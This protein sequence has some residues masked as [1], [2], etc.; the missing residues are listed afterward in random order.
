MLSA[1]LPE[2][3]LR[4]VATGRRRANTGSGADVDVKEED[5]RR[6]LPATKADLLPMR[7]L[8]DADG[9]ADGA[10]AGDND[11]SLGA[12]TA[13]ASDGGSG[14]AW[15]RRAMQREQERGKKSKECERVV[16]SSSLSFLFPIEKMEK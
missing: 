4:M 9:V 6:L 5:E 16:S 11:E 2:S 13:A 7:V 1:S 10:A 8:A 14:G 15:A 3:A 12:F